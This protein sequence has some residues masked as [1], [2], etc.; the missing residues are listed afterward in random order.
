MQ[1]EEVRK[2]YPDQYVKLQILASHIE[3]NTKFVDEV[4][5]IRA[6]QDPKEATKELLKS[7]D[8]VIVS[9]T[10]NDELKVEIRTLRGLRGVVQHEN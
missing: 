2:I 9:H 6:I 7:K 4:A 3:G 1:W 10:A 8:G 5:L